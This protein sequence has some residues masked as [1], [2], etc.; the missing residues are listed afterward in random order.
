MQLHSNDLFIY[1][2]FSV[3]F[4]LIYT[5]YANLAYFDK[6]SHLNLL[7]NFWPKLNQIWLEWS[8]GGPLSKLCLTSL[9]PLH[10]SGGHYNFFSFSQFLSIMHILEKKI[11]L[12]SSAHKFE[13]ENGRWLSF[14][15]VQ[16]VL[17]S[18][19]M[20]PSHR[21][22]F[23]SKKYMPPPLPYFKVNIFPFPLSHFRCYIVEQPPRPFQDWKQFF[24]I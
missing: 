10:S 18:A 6:R 12:K 19:N 23:H 21:H 13:M 8:L 1:F 9:P 2:R 24:S 22:L 3:K 15:H 4:Q 14:C 7:W 11:T 5:N 20:S 16:V 17:Q